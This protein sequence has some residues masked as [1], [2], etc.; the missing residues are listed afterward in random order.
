MYSNIYIFSIPFQ[1]PKEFKEILGEET[2]NKLDEIHQLNVS[3]EERFKKMDEIMSKIPKE[4]LDKLPLPP[5]FRRLPEAAQA[6]VREIMRDFSIDASK[7]FAKVREFIKT[8]P[9]DQQKLLP[10]PPP[11]ASH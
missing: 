10:P 9:E 5:P 3:R 4:T 8:L 1:P 11:S 2:F 7:R 6:K